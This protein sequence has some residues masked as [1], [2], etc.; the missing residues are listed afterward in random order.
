[1]TTLVLWLQQPLEH[2]IA[3]VVV[4]IVGAGV[5]GLVV[6]ALIVWEVRSRVDTMEREVG[7][8]RD[9]RHDTEND[10][11]GERLRAK[12]PESD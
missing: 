7:R 3:D 10:A 4:Y 11:L 2:R 9:W 1:M 6:L 12:H 8:L 5:V